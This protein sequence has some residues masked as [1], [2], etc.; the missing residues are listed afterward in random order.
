MVVRFEVPKE[1]IDRV[2]RIA[3]EGP[4]I[5][6]VRYVRI[7]HRKPILPKGLRPAE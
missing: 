2:M 5:R 3:P 4:E 1:P 6:L 7:I